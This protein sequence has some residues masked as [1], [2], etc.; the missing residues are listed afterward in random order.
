MNYTCKVNS[1]FVNIE[2]HLYL[3]NPLFINN[4]V[5][6]DCEFIIY[7]SRSFISP[8]VDPLFVNNEVNHCGG[9]SIIC[10]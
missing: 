4:E 6:L 5:K 10:K 8:S 9:K 2:V 1:L 3:A 7:E